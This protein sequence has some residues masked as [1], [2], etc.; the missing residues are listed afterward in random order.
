[1]EKVNFKNSKGLNLV[2]HFYSSDSKA[3][4]IMTHGFTGDKT[5]WGR[6]DKTAE[7]LHDAGYNVLNF[8]FSGSGESDE[9][10]LTVD[11]QVDDLRSAIDYVKERGYNNVGLL[12]LSLGGLVSLRVYDEEIKTMVLWAPV[13]APQDGP[14][15]RYTPEQLQELGEKGYITKTRDKGVRKTIKIDKQMIEDRKNVNQESLCSRIKCPVLVVHGDQDERVPL[16]NS[17][18]AMQY[19]PAGS[20]LEVIAG[21]DHGF[22]DQL[23][24]F[25]A[26]SVSW[27]KEHLPV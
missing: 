10:S 3:V 4:I 21:A 27:Y 18:D 19:F 17:K 1:M 7:A 22:Y 6:F 2:G 25:I 13:T 26:H 24:Q 9:D 12:G 15:D 11:K 8:D 5:E 20:K 16:Q 23:D 14:T